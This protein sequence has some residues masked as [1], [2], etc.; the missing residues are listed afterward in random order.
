MKV[1]AAT[2]I[3]YCLLTAGATAGEVEIVDASAVGGGDG[4]FTFHV[5]LA[6]GDTGWDHY[7]DKLEVLVPDG[8]VPG[9]RALL[10]PHEN[11]QPFTRSLSGVE[12]PPGIS[13]VT[14]RAHDLVHGDGLLISSGS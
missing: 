7:A 2:A 5:T 12:I 14:I 13:T 8:T 11:E 10:H 1:S 3:A 6:H 9:T 4:R